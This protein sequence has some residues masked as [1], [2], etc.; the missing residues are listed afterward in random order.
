MDHDA[1][2]VICLGESEIGTYLLKGFYDF[3]HTYSNFKI[4]RLASL[5]VSKDPINKKAVKV[6]HCIDTLVSPLLVISYEDS[7][8]IDILDETCKLQASVDLSS[9]LMDIADI[10]LESIEFMISPKLKWS[11]RQR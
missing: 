9:P 5:D 8:R 2:L 6:L 3:E 7:A 4:T 10:D 11:S 1:F